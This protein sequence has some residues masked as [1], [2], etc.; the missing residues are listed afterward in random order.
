MT[1]PTPPAWF[2]KY[3]PAVTTIMVTVLTFVATLLTDGINAHEWVLI[4]GVTISAA[5]VALVPQLDTGIGKIAKTVSTFLLAGLTVLATASLGDMGT[6]EW[7]EVVLAACAAVGV[8]A[9][10]YDWPPA[11]M[12]VPG[13]VLDSRT[14]PPVR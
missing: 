13:Q 11:R 2:A 4:A 7:I 1:A 12:I 8:S 14:G 6:A 10:P 3:R 9:L 5:N